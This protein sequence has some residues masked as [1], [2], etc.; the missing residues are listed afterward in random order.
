MN[1]AL[2]NIASANPLTPVMLP[3]LP[4]SRGAM[5][6]LYHFLQYLQFRY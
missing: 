2:S 5:D 6:E 3:E 4:L 1:T